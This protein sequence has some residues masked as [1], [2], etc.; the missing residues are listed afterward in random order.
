MPSNRNRGPKPLQD[1]APATPIAPWFGGK[2]N[3]AKR[4]IAHIE[5]TPHTCYA[6]PFVG[7]G[8]VF[9]RRRKRPVSEIVNDING[10]VVNLFRVAREHPDELKRQFDLVLSSRTEFRRFLETPPDVLTDVQRAARFVYVQRLTFGG[11]PPAKANPGDYAPSPQRASLLTGERMRKLIVGAH[12]RLV[13]VH[14][15]CLNW[16]DFI[17]RYDRPFTLFYI[18]P[19]YWGHETD[20]GKGLF[21]R[22]DFARM[23]ETLRSLKGRFILSIN[24]RPEVRATFAGFAFEEVRTTYTA[25]ARAVKAVTELLITGGGKAG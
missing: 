4:I 17:R 18:D 7:M 6:E 12:G 14:V 22:D 3:L 2:R 25:N 15:E 11:R 5:A 19:P 21:A 20:Y 1:V 8:G 23:A 9:L 13:G 10:D 24:N 16:A